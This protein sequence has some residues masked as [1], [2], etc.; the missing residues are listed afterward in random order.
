MSVS[1]L[2]VVSGTGLAKQMFDN[3]APSL[4]APPGAAGKDAKQRIADLCN[5]F[6]DAVITHIKANGEVTVAVVAADVGLQ[7]STPNG[8]PTAG[9]AVTKQ[10]STKG[11]IA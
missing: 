1:S 4:G 10:L 8:S 11:S 6:A 3:Y 7:T 5:A 9:P 2:G